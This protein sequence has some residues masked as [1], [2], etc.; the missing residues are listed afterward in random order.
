[1]PD[2][3]SLFGQT[4]LVSIL[5]LIGLL[6][7]FASSLVV[8]YL[9]G[10]SGAR[11]AFLLAM[12]VPS[13]ISL[14]FSGV[15]ALIFTPIF[16]D[17]LSR[18]KAQAWRVASSVV[19]TTALML[20]VATAV[21][22]ATSPYWTSWLVHGET[23]AMAPLIGQ[24][25]RI[26]MPSIVF[27]GIAGLFSSLHYAEHRFIAPTI[28]PIISAVITV[29]VNIALHRLW[30]IRSL[31]LGL[32]LG[33]IS[34]AILLA[35]GLLGKGRLTFRIAL[36][37][38]G[39][40]RVFLVSLPLILAG[41][42]YRFNTGLERIIGSTLPAGSI[43]YIGYATQVVAVFSTM[44][45]SAAAVTIYPLLSR[46]WAEGDLA[47][48]R[49]YLAI[50]VRSV[51]LVALPTG[52]VVLVFG[53][54]LVATAYERGAFDHRATVAVTQSLTWLVAGYVGANVG[55]IVVRCFYVAGQTTVLAVYTA[56]ETL[57]YVGLGFALSR[58][59]SYC[60]LA[61]ASSIRDAIGVA[62]ALFW[63]SRVFGGI[64]GRAMLKD[65]VKIAAS[66]TAL[67]L[68]AVALR[69]TLSNQLPPVLVMVVG[70]AAGVAVYALMLTKI[71]KIPEA[72]RLVEA[73][74]A[75]VPL[76]RRWASA[77]G[78]GSISP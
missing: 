59:F 22:S 56:A 16:I 50:A 76:L 31:A 32:T 78:P 73:A 61:A 54:T 65:G 33:S 66:A 45:S 17:Y 64:H 70:T 28:A 42:L 19:C 55:N 60:G 34:N 5:S 72:F 12:V 53:S 3:R 6:A 69:C 58:H 20:S 7:G 1:M 48:L 25:A 57:I 13:Y 49:R 51:L 11:D 39:L 27:T 77:I 8:A 15:L 18:D 24:L 67:L 63:S 21:G 30:G 74:I 26:L 14:V 23:R 10:A 68:V 41:F 43:S 75:R 40:R 9:Y 52:A 62:F 2:R 44:T 36:G 47:S 4:V 29:V 38:P 37:D 35:P 71:F 46:S